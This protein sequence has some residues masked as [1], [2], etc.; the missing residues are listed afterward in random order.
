M[1]ETLA[2]I[3]S[4][5]PVEIIHEHKT[6]TPLW[7]IDKVRSCHGMPFTAPVPTFAPLRWRPVSAPVLSQAMY[8]ARLEQLYP[9]L[10]S[11]LPIENVVLAGRSAAAVFSDGSN[12][13]ADLYI[14]GIPAEEKG[15]LWSKVHE[16][17]CKVR[18]IPR[19]GVVCE[20]GGLCNNI[21]GA[22]DLPPLE[23]LDDPA[24]IHAAVSGTTVLASE[25]TTP[26]GSPPQAPDTD[27][28]ISSEEKDMRTIAT[29]IG[30]GHSLE[31]IVQ[32]LDG[33]QTGANAGPSQWESEILREGV[34][35]LMGGCCKGYRIILRAFPDVESLAKSFSI[36]S[37]QVVFDGST[38][39]I[40]SAAAY[41]HT[42]RV[43]P[44]WPEHND[45][46]YM[47]GLWR[48][49][50]EGFALSLCHLNPSALSAEMRVG[51][52]ML[53]PAFSRGNF[54]CGSLHLLHPMAEPQDDHVTED[55]NLSNFMNAAFSQER[56]AEAAN[57]L[58]V[59]TG[60]VGAAVF[61]RELDLA[62]YITEPEPNMKDLLTE[63][64][65]LEILS[66]TLNSL[67][68][69]SSNQIFSTLC[70]IL[71]MT[72]A[73]F[74]KF[75]QTWAATAVQNPGR[76]IDVGAALIPFVETIH[77]NYLTMRE[78]PLNWWLSGPRWAPR[79]ISAQEW[80]GSSFVEPAPAIAVDT[81]LGLL[82]QRTSTTVFST[83]CALCQQDVY[84]GANDTIVL[85]CGHI[86]H[87]SNTRC[88]GFTN[89]S[90]RNGTCP[91]CRVVFRKKEMPAEV[92]PLPNI[93]WPD[94]LR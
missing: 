47:F 76:P 54:A 86:F 29:L 85:E 70:T 68:Q 1:N 93:E 22:D 20:C 53:T 50:E 45:R 43:I 2:S 94:P 3:L 10:Q 64:R 7:P 56:V 28:S 51:R 58:R 8:G 83:E 63:E 5:D 77:K 74:G 37:E 38:T 40:S 61:V 60:S 12:Q 92:I 49:F 27:P 41:S 36:P 16:I 89:W 90:E 72:P 32:R 71:G 73:N 26:V 91:V 52:L 81:L 30:A 59:C 33:T 65:F 82:S 35:T 9:N 80:Y 6:A 88:P 57:F 42:Y 46:S 15:R 78:L 55:P 75:I 18:A 87:W 21:G 79:P 66:Q 67:Q 24:T 23:G 11:V 62:R 4:R 25:P 17:A 44:V 19:K 31:D 39:L 69:A 34:V 14:V 48:G 13:F 84:A